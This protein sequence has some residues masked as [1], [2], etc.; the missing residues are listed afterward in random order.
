MA[1]QV[2][3]QG[4]LGNIPEECENMA[5][6]HHQ[7][8]KSEVL[9]ILACDL[10]AGQALMHCIRP[11]CFVNG[12]PPNADSLPRRLLFRLHCLLRLLLV[13]RGLRHRNVLAGKLALEYDDLAFVVNLHAIVRQRRSQRT[14]KAIKIRPER[15]PNFGF[16][17]GGRSVDTLL[18]L[19]RLSGKVAIT[20][21]PMRENEL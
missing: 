15:I 7:V 9:Q 2:D 10:K 18:D 16:G 21:H 14:G 1:N 17:A 4:G 3:D 20:A 19:L 5:Q 13:H 11:H 6:G 12:G 8:L